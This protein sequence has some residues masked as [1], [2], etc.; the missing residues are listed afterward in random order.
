MKRLGNDH[1][2]SED[3]F[4]QMII[5]FRKSFLEGENYYQRVLRHR[6][7]A[8]VSQELLQKIYAYDRL[9]QYR[10]EMQ[11]ED[12]VN[13]AVDFAPSVIK[14]LWKSDFQHG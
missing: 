4:Y 7:P 6:N 1:L 2:I 9:I 12:V 11:D 8:E 13:N 3:Q 10:P 5:E 14:E